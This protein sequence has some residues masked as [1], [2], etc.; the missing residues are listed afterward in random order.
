MLGYG[1]LEKIGSKLTTI[2]NVEHPIKQY[3]TYPSGH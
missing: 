1:N 2:E 3:Q